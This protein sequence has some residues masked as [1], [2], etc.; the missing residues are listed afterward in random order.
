V[1]DTHLPPVVGCCLAFRCNVVRLEEAVVAVVL[2]ALLEGVV[3]IP[4]VVLPRL[5]SVVEAPVLSAKAVV[6]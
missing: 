5:R 1:C 6:L 3:L 4:E 2:R